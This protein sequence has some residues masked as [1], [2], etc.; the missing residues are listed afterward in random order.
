MTN[1]KEIL[2]EIDYLIYRYKSKKITEQEAIDE[3]RSV[4]K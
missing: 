1:K 3:I 2:S 4:L